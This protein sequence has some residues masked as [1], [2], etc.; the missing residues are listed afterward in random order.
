MFY[1]LRWAFR[2]TPMSLATRDRLRQRFLDRHADLVPVGPRG[3]LA[4]HASNRRVRADERALG[5]VEYRKEPLIDPLP[6][7]LVA[8]YLPQFHAIPENDAWWGKG[9]TEWRNVTRALPQFE[10]HVQPKLPGDLGFYDLRNPEVMREQAR[11]AREYGIGAFCF[12]FY[13]FG[14]KTLLEAPLRNW[15]A[16]P[17]IDLPFCLCW[18]NEKWS[19]TWDGRGNEILIDQQHSAADDLAFIAY[20]ADYLR[21]PRYL[22]VDGKP[23]LLV[24]RPGLFPEMAATAERWRGWCRDNGIGEIH[25]AYVQSFE[26]PVPADIGF[27]A[28]V[29]FPPNLGTPQHADPQPALLTAGYAGQ[30]LDWRSMSAQ[31]Q[32]RAAESGYR[33]YRG[34]N[35]GWDNEARRSGRGRSFVHDSPRAY[36]DWLRSVLEL[37]PTHAQ[38]ASALVFINAWNEWAEGAVLE[39]TATLGHAYLQATRDALSRPAVPVGGLAC[40]I[41]AWYPE[42][43]APLL[44]STAE[45]LP[46]ARLI[47]TTAPEVAEQVRAIVERTCPYAEVR[48]CEN[49]GRDILPFL[50]V[51]Q[52]LMDEGIELVLKLHT[53]RSVHRADGEQWRREL[54]DDLLAPEAVQAVL[55]AFKAKDDL[56]VIGP[57]GHLLRH[58]DYLGAN[59]ASVARLNTLMGVPPAGPDQVFVAGSM[60]WVR[61]RALRPLLD[62][63]LF[64]SDFEDEAGQVDG[65]LA[66]AVER[67]FGHCVQVAGFR[68]HSMAFVR[69]GIEPAIHHY[70][71]AR[72]TRNGG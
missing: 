24:Y 36:R 48:C 25:L 41:H 28:A 34:V 17:S 10:G 23:V 35:P 42:L 5:Y 12:Y 6:A 30:V 3:V 65:T 54:V 72:P 22:R 57:E 50:R 13:W 63:C 47:V 71:Y 67:E 33:V 61:L 14:G 69:S 15:L 40:I 37:T 31:F 20:I 38:P 32:Q 27:D 1:A 66:H 49:R 59:A 68:V 44:R 46:Q 29:E 55:A 9:F 51:A 62:A 26:R 58:A 7:T 64:A 11:L 56:G 2:I 52:D 21:D 19:R 18:A 39:P 70:P 60:F 4:E 45:H 43:L 16:D 8:F 53:K